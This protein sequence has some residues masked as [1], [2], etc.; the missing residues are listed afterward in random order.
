MPSVLDFHDEPLAVLVLAVD[1]VDATSVVS[2]CR[3]LLLV[4]EG[5]VDDP[6]LALQQVVQEIN[7]EVLV[8]LL[9]EDALEAHVRE[10]IDK[11]SHSYLIIS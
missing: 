8:D 3:Q 10:W 5:D 6:F 7:E 11:T 1:V 4:E 2:R 9:P